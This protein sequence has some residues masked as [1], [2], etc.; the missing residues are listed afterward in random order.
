MEYIDK[1]S[2]ERY[3]DKAFSLDSAERN[4][5]YHKMK[6]IIMTTVSSSESAT[7]VLQLFSQFLE[8]RKSDIEYKAAEKHEGK[9]VG[10]VFRRIG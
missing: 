5:M 9:E 4:Q 6:E 3:V 10:A 1:H 2:F 7:E 8:D